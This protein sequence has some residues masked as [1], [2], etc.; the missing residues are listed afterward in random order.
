MLCFFISTSFLENNIL[1]TYDKIRYAAYHLNISLNKKDIERAIYHIDNFAKNL[2]YLKN[3]I[4][5]LPF[6]KDVTSILEKVFMVLKYEVY[7][8]LLKGNTDD[9]LEIVKKIQEAIEKQDISQ[10]RS[11]I[12]SYSLDNIDK[13][14]LLPYETPGTL[15]KGY[16]EILKVTNKIFYG[17]FI[18]RLVI[19]IIT[20]STI[21]Y[22]IT[23]YIPSIKFDGTFFGALIV[24]AL[25]LTKQY[26]GRTEIKRLEK[27]KSRQYEL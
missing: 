18:F 2:G 20:L 1:S 26:D 7:P 10:L 23:G 6:Q 9:Y 16:S 4:K 14:L 27:L 8:S 15:T 17:N 3:Q 19:F 22:W 13:D 12:Q 5:I 25:G 11:S 24:L 21:G